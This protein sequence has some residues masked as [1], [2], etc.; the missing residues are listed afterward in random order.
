M[1]DLREHI[2]RA[3]G[4]DVA[5][6]APVR[7]GDVADAYRVQLADGESVFA[8]TRTG[9]PPGFFTTEA[10]G[11]GTGLGL[12]LCRDSLRRIGGDI[13]LLP[14]DKGATFEILVPTKVLP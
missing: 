9:A 4:R 11:R 1:I 14:S 7:G 10:A 2:A 13:Q 8:K 5:A 3:L 12:A 6:L